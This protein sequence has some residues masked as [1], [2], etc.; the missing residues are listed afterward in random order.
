MSMIAT[1]LLNFLFEI[2]YSAAITKS[3]TFLAPLITL[4]EQIVNGNLNKFDEIEIMY[5]LI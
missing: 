4:G 1:N 5:K 2:V 3:N